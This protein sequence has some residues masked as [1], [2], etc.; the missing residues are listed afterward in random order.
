MTDEN[1]ILLSNIEKEIHNILNCSESEEQAVE[2]LLELG[3][4]TSDIEDRLSRYF[5]TYKEIDNES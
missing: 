3:L 1:D 5:D 2:E 4:N